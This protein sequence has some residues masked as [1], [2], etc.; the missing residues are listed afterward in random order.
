MIHLFLLA[1][2]CTMRMVRRYL[3]MR[4]LTIENPANSTTPL[5]FMIKERDTA[6]VKGILLYK[7]SRMQTRNLTRLVARIIIRACTMNWS[8]SPPCLQFMKSLRST[9]ITQVVTKRGM[10]IQLTKVSIFLIMAVPNG[11]PSGVAMPNTKG[12]KRA[13]NPMRCVI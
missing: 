5:Q 4:S 2:L 12:P 11:G 8:I 3:T 6:S 7:G 13:K 9:L 1:N 10:N